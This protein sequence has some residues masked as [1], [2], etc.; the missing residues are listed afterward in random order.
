MGRNTVRAAPRMCLLASTAHCSRDVGPVDRVVAPNGRVEVD[1]GGH[2]PDRREVRVASDVGRIECV[3]PNAAA[4]CA[5]LTSASEGPR[6]GAQDGMSTRS[7]YDGLG[8]GA[9]RGHWM[10][11]ALTLLFPVAGWCA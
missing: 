4:G 7:W 3:D 10:G 9:S 2:H 11:R 6:T 8:V 5:G 1:T